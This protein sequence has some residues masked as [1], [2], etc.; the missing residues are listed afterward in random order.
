MLR[1]FA[2]LHRQDKTTAFHIISHEN[3]TEIVKDFYEPLLLTVSSSQA[4]K[5]VE[6]NRMS[7]ALITM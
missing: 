3:Q 6:K 1:E 4:T 7:H 2:D 5:W